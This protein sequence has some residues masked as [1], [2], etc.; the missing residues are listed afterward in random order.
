MAKISLFNHKL[1]YFVNEDK[2]VVTCHLLDNYAYF[3][4]DEAWRQFLNKAGED[5]FFDYELHACINNIDGTR[6]SNKVVKAFPKKFG[7]AKCHPDDEFDIE[8]G[9]RIACDRLFNKLERARKLYIRMCFD[10]LAHL[11]TNAFCR[12]A[13]RHCTPVIKA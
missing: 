3:N 8:Q 12:A 9:K 1:K 6:L 10:T 7:E 13:K 4:P 11:T 2:G 5:V